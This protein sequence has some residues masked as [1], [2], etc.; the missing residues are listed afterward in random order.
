MENATGE[1]DEWYGAWIGLH[2]KGEENYQDY[3]NEKIM[4]TEEDDIID[5]ELIM[6]DVCLSKRE[7]LDLSLEQYSEMVYCN[8][9]NH[10]LNRSVVWI[11]GYLKEY[12]FPEVE[13]LKI[14]LILADQSLQALKA[15]TDRIIH[16]DEILEINNQ[17]DLQHEIIKIAELII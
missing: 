10:D 3:W 9:L 17:V 4:H 6:K 7:A 15:K 11:T 12:G 8:S 13:A 16:E 5:G 1:I 2:E 14:G